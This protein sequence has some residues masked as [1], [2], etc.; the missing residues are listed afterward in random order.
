VVALPPE[1]C[2]V[3]ATV[4]SLQP[5]LTASITSALLYVAGLANSSAQAAPAPEVTNV[6]FS[7]GQPELNWTVAAPGD[8]YTVQSSDSLTDGIW[9]VPRVEHLWPINPPSWR[10][11]RPPD[12][13]VRFYRVLAVPPAQRGQVLSSTLAQ[14]LSTNQIQFLFNFAGIPLTPQ[15]GVRLYKLVYETIDVNGGRTR[16]S[17]AL[18]V[19]VGVGQPLPLVSYQHGTL[20]RTNDAPSFMSLSGEV[21]V[22]VAFA[23]TGYAAAV[24][25]LLGLGDSPGLHPYHVSRAEASCCV[26][27]LRAV[28]T[29]CATNGPALGNKLFLCG[30]S[31]GGHVTMSLL[32]DLEAYYMNEFQITA[33]APMAGAYDLSGVTA[34]DFLSGRVQPNPYYFA[35]LLAAYQDVY[36]FAPTLADLLRAPYHTNLP[37]LLRGGSTGDQI[38]AVMP[39]D[40]VQILKPEIL[41]SLRQN[42]NHPFRQALRDNDVYDW[43][44]QCLLRLH[45]CSGDQDV[46]YTNSEVALARFHALGATQVELTNT[47]PGASHGDCAFPSLEAAKVWFDSLR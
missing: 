47:V 18:A 28:R 13:P 37:P 38:D 35:Y 17:G 5:S 39:S 11:T 40:P 24:P 21:S 19:P 36:R 8:A 16:A 41:A 9:L 34:D 10:D 29:F 20:T 22:G 4:K 3:G 14:T 1:R 45:H 27:M 12:A 25:D 32:R 43:R 6:T 42:P 26:D 7:A 30:Y 15:Y 23:T 44:P 2:H 46:V 33:G 31:E